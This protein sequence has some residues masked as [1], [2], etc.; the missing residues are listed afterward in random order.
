RLHSALFSR[1]ALW[2]FNTTNAGKVNGNSAVDD[3]SL[4]G[5]PVDF[6]LW[7]KTRVRAYQ[8]SL[9]LRIDP[10]VAVL[11][12]PKLGLTVPVFNGTDDLILNRGLGT[13]EGTNAPG[14]G[15]NLGIAGHR[16][17]FF[18]GLKDIEPGDIIEIEIPG[19]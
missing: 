8:A 9:A 13:I 6:S 19:E 15:G 12:I 16:D 1:I 3:R 14:A 17:G 18:R 4:S 11:S 10:P 2:E 7:G 5:K